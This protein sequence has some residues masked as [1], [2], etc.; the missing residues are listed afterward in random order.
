MP[1]SS[2]GVSSGATSSDNAMVRGRMEPAFKR[3]ARKVK[4][5]QEYTVSTSDNIYSINAPAKAPPAGS[6]NRGGLPGR[7]GYQGPDLM[8]GRSGGASYLYGDSSSYEKNGE[9]ETID[10]RSCTLNIEWVILSVEEVP[11][12]QGELTVDQIVVFAA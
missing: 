9:I 4:Y 11:M 3:H 12:E 10:F 7:E 6:V 1:E 2:I 8:K 5:F